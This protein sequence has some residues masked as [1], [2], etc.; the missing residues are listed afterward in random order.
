MKKG[1]S[2]TVGQQ[3]VNTVKDVCGQDINFIN[4]EGYI[5]ASTNE[6][7]INEFHEIGKQCILQRTSIEVENDNSFLGTQKGVNIPF[8]YN[9]DV[10]AAIGISGVPDE[11]RK[12]AYLAQ[13]ITALILRE[14]ELDVKNNSIREQVSYIIRCLIANLPIDETFLNDFLERNQ[15]EEE[16]NYCSIVIKLESRYNPSNLSLVEHNIFQTFD[17]IGSRFYSFQ[18]P[19]EY[20]LLLEAEN[21]KQWMYILKKI[22]NQYHGLL[23]I[24]IGRS[25]KLKNQNQSYEEAKIAI[26]STSLTKNIIGFDELDLEILYGEIPREIKKQFLAKTLEYLDEEEQKLLQIYFSY[27]KSLKKTCDQLYLHKNTLQYKLDG[28]WHKCGYNPRQFRDAV[29]LYTALNLVK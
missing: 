15:I 7:R 28:I 11:V 4:K 20:I 29:V 24:G 26:S 25:H 13:K 12:Y 14:N 17:I 2:K 16:G 23:K 1:I 18:Y 27:D 10:I 9:G 3:I 21:L 22:A 19:D 8:L 5:F 6:K